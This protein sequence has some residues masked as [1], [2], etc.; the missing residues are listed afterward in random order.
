[1]TSAVGG[2]SPKS[3]RK[4]HNQQISVRDKGGGVKKSDN[5]AFVIYGSPLTL[6]TLTSGSF[7]FVGREKAD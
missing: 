2:G 1:M 3:L 4:E 5:F 6:L 7:F